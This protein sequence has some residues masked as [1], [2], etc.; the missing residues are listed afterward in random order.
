MLVGFPLRE[1]LI[2]LSR[3]QSTGTRSPS[4]G[5]LT[6]ELA[7]RVIFENSGTLLSRLH[8]IPAP[9]EFT[10]AVEHILGRVR[11]RIEIAPVPDA[12]KSFLLRRFEELDQELRNL[13]FPLSSGPTHG[14]AHIKNL[15]V[16]NGVPVFIDFERFSW[17]QPEWDLALTATEYQTAGWWTGQEYEQFSEA[18]G[19]DVMAWA[20]FDVLRAVHEIKMTTWLM[21]NV[22]ESREIADEY[23]ARIR[24][25]RDGER[26]RAWRPF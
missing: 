11:R 1:Y 10:L 22:R 9:A 18:Y 13:R 16:R 7:R 23:R 20:G 24:T 6:A 8:S 21:Q 12:D 5:I 3:L 19:Y 4:G 15:M 17:G 14:D 25:I 2:C 26:K